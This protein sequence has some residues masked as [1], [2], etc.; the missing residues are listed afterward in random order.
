M[1]QAPATEK[2][3]VARE[4]NFLKGSFAGFS[5]RLLQMEKSRTLYPTEKQALRKCF[6]LVTTVLAQ[7]KPLAPKR[8]K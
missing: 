7:W 6:G 4:R 8:R 1:F 5:V 2:Q 3:K